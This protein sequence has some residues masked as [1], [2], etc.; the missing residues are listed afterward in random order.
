MR[1]FCI[2]AGFA[3]GVANLPAPSVEQVVGLFKCLKLGK[4]FGLDM[5]PVDILAAAPLECARLAQPLMGRFL[6]EG[7]ELAQR[8]G[9]TLVPL[10][11]LPPHHNF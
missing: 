11:K 6:A 8:S 3:A 4:S 5:I 7:R 9:G 10:V 2:P 1:I